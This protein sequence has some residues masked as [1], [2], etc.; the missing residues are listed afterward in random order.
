MAAISI[1]SSL[2]S[3]VS[4]EKCYRLYLLVAIVIVTCH[5]IIKNVGKLP[6]VASQSCATFDPTLSTERP[7]I[8][9]G[10]SDSELH[11]V[12]SCTWLVGTAVAQCTL[13]LANVVTVVSYL[14][15]ISSEQPHISGFSQNSLSHTVYC[16][17]YIVYCAVYC[18][19]YTAQCM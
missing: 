16:V 10:V 4:P 14:N 12:P 11:N 5:S 18:I 19:H 2:L 9:G 8:S 17:M 15:T 13:Y 7:H 1:V 6:S 3:I